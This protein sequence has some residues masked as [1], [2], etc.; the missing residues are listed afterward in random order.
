MATTLR[1]VG[2]E[3]RLSLIEHL[4]ELRARIVVCLVA[5]IA[6]TAV[7]MWQN[8]RV[9]DILNDP[10]TSTQK[11]STKDPIQAGTLYDQLLARYTK[12]SSAMFRRQAALTVDPQLKTMLNSL[13]ASGD[14]LAA[15]APEVRARRPVTL[16]V[17]E[18]FMQTLKVSAYAGLLLSLP[19]I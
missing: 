8:Q 1:S 16:G 15:A 12:Q 9:L 11:A 10:L 7:C 18:P 4:T 17:S 13:A 19:L 5:F 14:R 2:H 3:D 6:C